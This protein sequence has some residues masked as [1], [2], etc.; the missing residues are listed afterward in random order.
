MQTCRACLQKE[1]DKYYSISKKIHQ[2]TIGQMFHLLT[3]LSVTPGDGL[4]DSFCQECVD[5]IVTCNNFRKKCLKSDN[6]LRTIIA[7]VNS[8]NELTE[9]EEPEYL[10]AT[11]KGIQLKFEATE[12]HVRE[13]IYY[14]EESPTIR[15][16]LVSTTKEGIELQVEE[17][18]EYE[19]YDV[20]EDIEIVENVSTDDNE[21]GVSL[22]GNLESIDTVADETDEAASENE[23][24]AHLILR[25]CGCTG[26]QFTSVEDLQQHMLE[27]HNKESSCDSADRCKCDF[28]YENRNNDVLLS[29]HKPMLGPKK[30]YSCNNCVAIYSS[31]SALLSHFKSKHLGKRT[32][33][34]DVCQKAFYTSNTLISH[35][36]THGEKKFQCNTCSKMFLRR[37]DLL[38][39]QKMHST[40]RPYGCNICEMRFKTVAHLRAHQ[41]VHTGERTKK[42]RICGKGFRTYSDRRVHELQHENIHPF[43]CNQCDKKYGRNYKL[44]IHMRKVHTGE[45]PFECNDC[46]KRFFQRFELKAHRRVEHGEVEGFQT[47]EVVEA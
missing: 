16:S 34:C 43:K 45:R 5:F 1:A 36:L 35:R 17:A 24:T 20:I 47:V 14:K 42:C 40:E 19:L 31:R 4:P 30:K 39:H 18:S 22:E 29:Q 46:S 6:H 28:C 41:L 26:L 21:N 32:Y 10:E 37:W 23:L 3:G 8:E 2:V 38:I 15:Q 33:V 13:E 7:N 9:Y 11:F 44:Q 27:V 12:D 25:C